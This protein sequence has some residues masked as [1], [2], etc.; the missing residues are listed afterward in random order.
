MKEKTS[1][2]DI[3]DS[4]FCWQD[5]V[6]LRKLR[7][8]YSGKRLGSLLS[9][10]LVLTEISSNNG[11]SQEIVQTFKSIGKFAGLQR[12][13]V[14]DSLKLLEKLGILEVK[15]ER[16]TEGRF[17][18]STIILLSTGALKPSRTETVSPATVKQTILEEEMQEERV[19]TN[20]ERRKEN[21]H[22]LSLILSRW[23]EKSIVVHSEFSGSVSSKAL[24]L[25]KF[26]GLEKVLASIDTYAEVYHSPKTYFKHKWTLF[27]F[28]QRKNGC[29]VFVYKV[30]GDY[31]TDKES[32][33]EDVT[34]D[35]KNKIKRTFKGSQLVKEEIIK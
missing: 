4:A 26:F 13:T 29:E 2:R 27:E 9:L 1:V 30:F 24:N 35:F 17:D 7:E 31:L 23:N 33:K 32:E 8:L 18:T 15:T 10:Y 20:L 16:N 14:S 25:V 21:I 22:T 19:N 5:K 34:W 6:V 11:N 12:Q 28:L 3:R